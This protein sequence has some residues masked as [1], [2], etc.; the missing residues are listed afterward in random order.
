M[1]FY[2]NAQLQMT[3]AS[4]CHFASCISVDL[5]PGFVQ[6]KLKLLIVKIKSL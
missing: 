6:G 1:E 4:F 2:A 5:H 3:G